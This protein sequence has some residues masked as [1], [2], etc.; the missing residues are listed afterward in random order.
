M[1]SMMHATTLLLSLWTTWS[2][3]QQGLRDAPRWSKKIV[4][5]SRNTGTRA[6]L[7]PLA[8]FLRSLNPS[9]AFNPSWSGSQRLVSNP[10]LVSSHSSILCRLS[11]SATVTPRWREALP[12]KRDALDKEILGVA[13][14]SIANLAVIPVVGAVDTFWIGRMGDALALAGQ[15]AANQVF[16]SAFFVIAFIPTI[17]APL[18]AKAAGRGDIDTARTRVSEALFLANVL[19]AIGTVMLV[20]R[21]SAFLSLVI[22]TGA[23]SAEYAKQYLQLRSI[24][25]IPAL[26]SS[27]GFAAFRGL[28]DTVTPLKV[29]LASNTLN[30][31]L[32]PI[33]IFAAKMGVAGAA[34]A[35]AV[36]EVGAGILYVFLLM[37]RQLLRLEQRP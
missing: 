31:V 21:P 6:P 32:D 19:G 1:P 35:T 5:P 28:L 13:L 29:S 30:L 11:A 8:S 34:L 23:P 14:P 25:L 37:K 20:L 12:G 7:K 27:I 18:V 17:T 33:A 10:S 26:I 15:A 9:V 2:S 3:G 4:A 22:P 16:F 36:S 24:S